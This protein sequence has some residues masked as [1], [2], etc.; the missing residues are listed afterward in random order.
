MKPLKREFEKV[1][2]EEWLKGEI[3]KI[4]YEKQHEFTFKG[5]KTIA[6]AVRVQITLDG[7]KDPKSTGWW[8]FNYNEKSKLFRFFLEPLVEG[9]HSKLD[10]DFDH[11][12]HTRIKV[13]YT[14]NGEYQNLVMV[15]PDG[16]KIIPVSTPAKKQDAVQENDAIESF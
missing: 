2:V 4:E 1:K 14:T 15:R 10:F 3:S 13:M 6:P 7:Y 12:L 5:E 8:K 16:P 9:A 11:L